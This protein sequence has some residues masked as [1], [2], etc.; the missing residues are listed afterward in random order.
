MP[1]VSLEQARADHE[2]GRV[3]MI[4]IR[5]PHEHATGVAQ[6]VFLLPMSQVA[7]RVAEIPKQADQPVFLIC[8]NQNRSRALTEA[9]RE[10]GFT[11]IRYVNGGMSEWARRGWPMVKPQDLLA[12][13]KS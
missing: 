4:D 1:S 13:G 7:Q 11:N 5:E 2:A 8:N 9:L 6:G 10:Q 12:P 3:L